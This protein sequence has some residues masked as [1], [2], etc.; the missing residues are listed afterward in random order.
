V[1]RLR[2]ALDTDVIETLA[3]AAGLLR[4]ALALWQGSPPAGVGAGSPTPGALGWPI[5]TDR[6]SRR[7]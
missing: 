3:A 5:C 2:K 7:G 1:Y 4:S 6:R